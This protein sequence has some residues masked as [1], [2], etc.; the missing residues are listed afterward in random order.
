MILQKSKEQQT[1]YWRC[2]VVFSI[3]NVWEDQLN[4]DEFH[5]NKKKGEEFSIPHCHLALDHLGISSPDEFFS[6]VE[7]VRNRELY[8]WPE[9]LDPHSTSHQSFRDFLEE[10]L[11]HEFDFP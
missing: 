3:L 2:Q 9:Y 10:S 7:R 1:R 4:I 8:S 5:R 6:E 11:S